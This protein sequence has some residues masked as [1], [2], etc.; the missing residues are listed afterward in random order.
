MKALRSCHAMAGARVA[1][2]SPA[3]SSEEI[4]AYMPLVRKVVGRYVARLPPSVQRDDLMCAGT[5]G[6]V[7]ALRR[8]PDRRRASFLKYVNV[9]VRGAV[10][11][12]L[13]SLDW[14]SRTARGRLKGT[15]ES[16]SP[17]PCKMIP[18]EDLSKATLSRLSDDSSPSPLETAEQNDQRDAIRTAISLLH[19]R[20][21]VILDLFYFE[22][23]LL[24]DIAERLG[25]SKPRVSQLHSRAIAQLR[26]T[27]SSRFAFQIDHSRSSR[28]DALRVAP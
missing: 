9:R 3:V 7:D 1:D 5:C 13:R 14:L 6:L 12:E 2:A 18:F 8:N 21:R 16:G 24:K 23:V 15:Q 27:L 22:G 19:E 26:A 25:V 28:A 17:W 20:E 4:V 11:D 10:V